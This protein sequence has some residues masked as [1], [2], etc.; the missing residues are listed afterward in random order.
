MA[1]RCHEEEDKQGKEAQHLKGKIGQG[2]IMC[3]RQE[4]GEERIGVSQG[5]ELNDTENPVNRCNQKHRYS[6]MASIVQQWQETIIQ[7]AYGTDHKNHMQHQNCQSP[8]SP[9]D[10]S[11]KGNIWMKEDI[12]QHKYE[13]EYAH[14]Q[15]HDPIISLLERVPTDGFVGESHG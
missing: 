12:A 1:G 6:Q 4:Q 11:F 10:Q 9:N 13:Y 3:I 5:M 8:C 2:I 15:A 14:Q 7:S